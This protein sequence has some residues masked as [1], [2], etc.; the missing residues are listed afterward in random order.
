MVNRSSGAANF[1]ALGL[2][3][4]EIMI[5]YFTPNRS[6]ILVLTLGSGLL[7]ELDFAIYVGVIAS[8][9]VFVYEAAHPEVTVTLPSHTSDGL[10]KFREVQ[11]H[12]KA[13]CPQAC[14]ITISGTLYFGSV[15]NVERTIARLRK[16]RPRQKNLVLILKSA[17]KIDLAS[18]DMLIK[19]SRQVQE[20][21]GRLDLVV[22][23]AIPMRS[24]ER[25]HVIEELGEDRVHQSKSEAI[26][27][28]TA[29]F[30]NRVC[31]G[32]ILD[33]FNECDRIRDGE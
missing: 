14:V 31:Q 28:A 32:C 21:G 17:R 22:G 5:G 20:K 1:W 24:L 12:N 6:V 11:G 8:L 19:L 25:L 13:E 30:D 15:E 9:S 18:A 16:E 33:V 7:I 27:A 10:R 4:Q 2:T 23:S 26:S 29:A 3:S